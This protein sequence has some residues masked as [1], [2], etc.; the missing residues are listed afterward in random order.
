MLLLTAHEREQVGRK[1]EG[2]TEREVLWLVAEGKSNREIA[3]ALC[4][5]EETVE[6]HIGNVLDKLRMGSRTEAAL[7]VVQSGLLEVEGWGKPYIKVGF[8]VITNRRERGRMILSVSTPGGTTVPEAPQPVQA[9]G[10]PGG[11]GRERYARW[12][13]RREWPGREG[14]YIRGNPWRL[15]PETEARMCSC[16]DIARANT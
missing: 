12:W 3:Q 10:N 2:R 5:T 15:L 13:Q 9:R 8:S 14:V 1:W 7:W 16:R 4:V 11:R 6:K